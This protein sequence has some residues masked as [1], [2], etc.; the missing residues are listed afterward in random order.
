MKKDWLKNFLNKSG[1][2]IDSIRFLQ[3]INRYV[4]VNFLF[5]RIFR[6]RF[7]PGLLEDAVLYPGE[8]GEL[9]TTAISQ[10]CT[11]DTFKTTGRKRTR[12]TDREI[13]EL[14]ATFQDPAI[15]EVGVSDGSSAMEI[16]ENS[17]KFSQI[18]LSDS[19]ERFYRQRFWW[20]SAFYNGDKNIIGIKSAGFYLSLSVPV[21]F[22]E[23][24]LSP[25]E[26]INPYL[27]EKYG[28]KNIQ[29][30]NMFKDVQEEKVHLIKCAN[31]LNVSYFS[32]DQIRFAIRNLGHSLVEG[33]YLIASHNNSIYADGEAYSTFQKINGEVKHINSVNE[34]NI[35]TFFDQG[36][37]KNEQPEKKWLFIIP[38][39]EPGG[40]E[41]QLIALANALAN[42]GASIHVAVFYGR[43]QLEPSLSSKVQLHCLAKRG[44]WDIFPFSQRLIGLVR[45]IQPAAIYS[46]LG[47]PC[48]ISVLLSPFFPRIKVV[49]S[50][51]ASNVDLSQYDWLHRVCYFLETRLSRFPDHI[52][53]NSNA[54]RDYS[55]QQGFSHESISIVYNGIDTNLFKPDRA[56]GMPLREQW[57]PSQ[58]HLLIGI[59]A[60]LEP[61]K[62]HETFLQAVKLAVQEDNDLCFVCIGD[63]PSGVQLKR[64][65]N[66]LG[67]AGGLVWAGVQT[68]MPAVYN[69]LD[70]CC[71]SSAYGEGFPNV[72]GEAMSCDVPC[73]TTDVGD[74]AFVVGHTG[75][76]VPI[77][78]PEALASAILQTVKRIRNGNIPKT[79]TKVEE[80]Y[81]LERMVADTEQIL[82][83]NYR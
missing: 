71:L 55:I 1:P 20:G 35:S 29:R 52:V 7:S 18:I 17:S 44:R 62:D 38:S 79:R 60:R 9:F 8:K 45:E 26:T 61:M 68:D 57:C 70:V 72:L 28:I 76:V 37:K 4:W 75:I 46:F 27:K 39:L 80:D 63:G 25:I 66:Q 67:I 15:L 77:R 31:I 22:N 49:W 43:G 78:N 65:S 30:F 59:V 5:L 56:K 6:F 32:A 13:V 40:A 16:L 19:H 41:R 2:C 81:S 11:G 83:G 53:V 42:D 73:V 3:W 51:R 54:G 33:G 48:I 21:V 10:I 36:E 24:Q 14:A 64:L 34:H 47:V 23:T 50:V 58:D 74:A 82:L 12:K 69:A